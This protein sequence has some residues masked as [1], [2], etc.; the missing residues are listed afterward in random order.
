[1]SDVE[2]NQLSKILEDEKSYIEML[3]KF[4]EE[5]SDPRLSTLFQQVC[6]SHMNFY[7]NVSSLLD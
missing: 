1:M 5:S 6:A 7:N 4:S 2:I 3:K